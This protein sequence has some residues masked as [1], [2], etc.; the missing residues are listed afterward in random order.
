MVL[1][2]EFVRRGID[3]NGVLE[4]LCYRIVGNVE[5][6]YGYM[7]VSTCEID[8]VNISFAYDLGLRNFPSY[9]CKIEVRIRMCEE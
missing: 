2:I 3:R 1:W 8:F 9:K 5:I 4:S 7:I 6:K